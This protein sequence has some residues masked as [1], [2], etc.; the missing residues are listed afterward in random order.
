[1]NVNRELNVSADE[2]FNQ[3]QRSVLE[4]IKASTRKNIEAEQ[5]VDGYSY[6]KNLGT[7]MGGS[8]KVKV[9]IKE[10]HAPTSYKA[11]FTS[12][13]GVNS[14]AYIIQEIGLQK[15]N[16]HYEEGF[17][18]SSRKMDLNNKIVQLFY[19]MGSKRKINTLLK[20]METYI[21]QNRP[22]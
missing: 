6:H 8:S 3:I 2:F 4:D 16:V 9:T 19:T 15:I 11:D 7:K 5:V 10:L 17:S 21:I 18:G 13:N 1:M 20:N 14:I 12:G 22:M